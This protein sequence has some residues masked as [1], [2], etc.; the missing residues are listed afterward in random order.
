MVLEFGLA[1][2]SKS[3]IVVKEVHSNGAVTRII[4]SLKKRKNAKSKFGSDGKRF[5]VHDFN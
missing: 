1:S 2:S 3:Y 4:K 5:L